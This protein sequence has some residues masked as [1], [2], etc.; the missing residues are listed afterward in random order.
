MRKWKQFHKYQWKHQEEGRFFTY[1]DTVKCSLVRHKFMQS[2][3]LSENSEQQNKL[4]TWI[5]FLDFEYWFYDK[6]MRVIKCLQPQYD[7][8]WKKLVNLQVLRPSEIKKFICSIDSAFQHASEREWAEKAVK[9]TK[10]AVTSAQNAITNSQRFT[11][12]EKKAEQRLGFAQ[13]RLN[14]AVKSLKSIKWWNDL[15]YEFYKKTQLSQITNDGKWKRSYQSTK[16]DTECCSIL[17]WWI[18]E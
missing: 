11:L 3:K 16:K 17:L 14:A 9:A 7:E 12:S 13:F 4:T 10:L 6:D 18:L 8:A 5:E 1:I 2:F 15:I